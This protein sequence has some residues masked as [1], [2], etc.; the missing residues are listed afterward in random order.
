MYI[1]YVR[2]FFR[3]I[4]TLPFILTYLDT[5]AQEDLG[6]REL[7]FEK[8]AECDAI[9]Y[10]NP[11]QSNQLAMEA[12]QIGLDLAEDS[13][14][15]VSLNRLGAAN[16]SLGNVNEA[17]AHFL[18]S[19]EICE[20]NNFKRL[21]AQNHGNLGNVYS[22]AGLFFDAINSYKKEETL[23][24]ELTDNEFR[25]FVIHNNVGRAYQQISLFDSSLLHFEKAMQYL[26]SSFVNLFSVFY[27]NIA[28]AYYNHGDINEADSI[29]TF[30]LRNAEAYNSKRAIIRINQLFGEIA[31]TRGQ[32][33]KAMGHAQFAVEL[34]E[35]SKKKELLALTHKTLAK[36]FAAQQDFASA[37]KHELIHE[38]NL[39]A[40]QGNQAINE[41]ELLSYQQ[42]DFQMK[43]LDERNKMTTALA[44]QRQNAIQ[45]L[46]GG[47]LICIVLIAVI[48]E[49]NKKVKLQTEKL[50][51]L[52]EFK[53]RLFAIVSHDI[54]SPINSVTMIIDL[55]ESK[56][57]S[58]EE[59]DFLLPEIRKKSDRLND[60][61]DSL[62]KWAEGNLAKKSFNKVDIEVKSLLN[63]L[64]DELTDRLS[65]KEITIQNEVEEG[66]VMV[67]EPG[68]I[69]IVFRNLLI[70]AI[71][72]SPKGS[73]VG[74]QSIDQHDYAGIKVV[75]QG[76]G[77]SE[78]TLKGLFSMEIG[79]TDGTNGE[80]GNGLGLVLCNDFIAGQGGT[81]EVESA[82]GKGS[83]FRVLLPKNGVV[84]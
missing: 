77:M 70:N 50:S 76:V 62:L 59:L 51:V 63:E 13:L 25:R 22:S 82:V 71:K 67:A 19:L 17:L 56:H 21:L 6:Q 49:R 44:D 83:T 46:V 72:F 60:L 29:L 15:A 45:I 58:E 48:Y 53:T 32:A 47:L 18:A 30:A 41:L 24:N 28:E 61:L 9:L 14:L 42:R 36:S 7:F 26:D 78:E 33:D 79:S 69:R 11:T 73:N 75:D 34:A 43:I 3:L 5:V 16:W 12:N 68:T 27:Y 35:E 80:K 81:I 20:S 64:H 52:D 40:I 4:C 65:Q 1:S 54:K 66:F 55:L 57:V 10:D 8:I 74:V 31:L 37:Y 23:Q 84:Q 39:N 2:K 38:E